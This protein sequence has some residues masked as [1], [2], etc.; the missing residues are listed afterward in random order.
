MPWHV[1]K[2]VAD[3]RDTGRV[4]IANSRS[5]ARRTDWT[6]EPGTKY[7]IPVDPADPGPIHAWLY[8]ADDP[9]TSSATRKELGQLK[10]WILAQPGTALL[11]EPF[12]EAAC[13]TSLRVIYRRLFDVNQSDACPRCVEM[14]RLWHTEPAE[15]HRILIE[16][17]KRWDERSWRAYEELDAADWE[18]QQSHGTDPIEDDND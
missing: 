9:K 13:G 17:H 5:A 6:I 3:D 1:R 2:L 12:V 14:A 16:R 11:E 10:R 8:S 18:R 7:R 15:Y 4:T